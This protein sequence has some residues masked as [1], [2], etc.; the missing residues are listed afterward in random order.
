MSSIEDESTLRKG[1]VKHLATAQKRTS[2]KVEQLLFV[3]K[4]LK[5][6]VFGEDSYNPNDKYMMCFRRNELAIVTQDIHQ[7]IVIAMEA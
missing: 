5:L 4:R 3:A 6:G 2:D 7:R 1:F